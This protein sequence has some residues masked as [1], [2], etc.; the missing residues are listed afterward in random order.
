MTDALNSI[1]ATPAVVSQPNGR[2]TSAEDLLKMYDQEEAQKSETV[3]AKAEE[4]IRLKEEVAKKEAANEVVKNL[5]AKEGEESLEEETPTEDE[6]T[7]EEAEEVV[8]GFKAV[9]DGE[10]TVLPENAEF[11]LEINGKDVK[12]NLSDAIEAKLEQETFNRNMDSRL[13]H[14]ASEK[15]K[16]ESQKSEALKNISQVVEKAQKTG[17]PMDLFAGFARVV[18]PNVTPEQLVDLQVKMLQEIQR[19]AGVPNAWSKDQVEHF[20]VTEIA[21]HYRQREEIRTQQE[22]VNQGFQ[23]IEGKVGEICK[24]LN[25]APTKFGQLFH[26]LAEHE[27][28][29]GKMFASADD[30]TPEEVAKAH[31]AITTSQSVKAAF[32]KVDPALLSQ[33]TLVDEVYKTVEN[34]GFSVEDIVDIIK[35]VTK[36][37]SE[38]VQNLNRK[39]EKAKSK[40]LNSQI[41]AASA[42]KKEGGSLP[43]KPD[44]DEEFFFGKALKP[45]RPYTA[46]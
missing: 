14:I 9:V 4:Q 33:K 15:R 30:I 6:A 40:A 11:Q 3:D 25:I 12:F 10:E 36:R 7:E 19:R 21:K 46:R 18:N 44:E 31:I 28:G 24:E 42:T 5:E 20:K 23:E 22:Q 35:A 34:Q 43:A 29:P 39:V 41:R 2:A 27:V 8:E 17:D 16:F 32:N 1:V 37:S 13:N 38:S 45:V 26:L